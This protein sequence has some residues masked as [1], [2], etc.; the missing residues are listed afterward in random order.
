MSRVEGRKPKIDIENRYQNRYRKPQQFVAPL[1][2]MID[3]F[4]SGII[5]KASKTELLFILIFT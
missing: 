2:S 4:S 3:A 5:Y 1:Q